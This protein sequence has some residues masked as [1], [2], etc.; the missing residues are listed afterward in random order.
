MVKLCFHWDKNVSFLSDVKAQERLLKQ[1][2]HTA[3]AF[4][5][6]HLLIVGNP[7]A[8]NDAEMTIESFT[9]YQ[10]IRDK[11]T[12]QYV[13]LTEHGTNLNDFTVP[14]GDLIYVL[15]SNYAEPVITAGDVTVGLDA[16]IPLW[17]VVAAGVILYGVT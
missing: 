9:N 10:E 16:L 4:G 8:N 3:K 1:W 12:E 6:Y 13:I 7:P 5:I 17:D 2:T 15:G 11:Y 14:E